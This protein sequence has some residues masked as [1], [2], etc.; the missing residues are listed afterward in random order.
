MAKKN[1]EWFDDKVAL[2]GD[3]I[4]IMAAGKPAN[5]PVEPY[6]Y[7]NLQSSFPYMPYG[8]NNIY[9]NDILK[10]VEKNSIIR[11]ALDYKANVMASGD[12]EIGYWR[13][14]EVEKEKVF[15]E[16]YLPEVDSFLEYND[17]HTY[18]QEALRDLYWWNYAYA[19]FVKGD[20]LGI[21]K[22]KIVQLS[23][24]DHVFGRLEKQNAKTG[25]KENL[26]IDANWA[27]PK[28]TPIDQ[29]TKVP[30]LDPYYM[31]PDAV[32]NSTKTRF[33]F[34][35]YF[36]TPGQIYY[37][38]PSWH[39][40]VLSGWVTYLDMI[41]EFKKYML[42]NLK[43]IRY[44]V[45]IPDK[46]WILKHGK[47][48]F[49]KAPEARKKIMNK[50]LDAFVETISGTNKAGSAILATFNTDNAGNALSQWKIE[51]LRNDVGTGDLLPESQE[52][53]NN[54][55]F[56][57]A[58]HASLIGNTPGKGM[59]AGSGS[60]IRVSFNNLIIANTPHQKK[61]AKA[62]DFIARINNWRGPKGEP[63]C[64]RIDND[65]FIQTL[66]SVD[67]TGRTPMANN[68]PSDGTDT[69]NGGD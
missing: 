43:N 48:F 46:W 45:H 1:I 66:N 37:Q 26:Y 49:Q 44:V 31:D 52:G 42:Q 63:L 7:N 24:V 54:V 29:L 33:I 36:H 21:S 23:T 65:N 30:L 9:P 27:G 69:N 16:Y 6:Q 11:T 20:P 15:E 19:D 10:L 39:T 25:K 32:I 13:W 4:L 58:L 18:F 53:A 57:L 60:D 61:V 50:E 47:D 51:Q 35:M 14:D 38:P 67:P 56:A 34:P 68:T 17:L 22:N 8:T 12:I 28:I 3:D 41:P 62:F 2:V 55:L 5:V 64:C 40:V 59:G